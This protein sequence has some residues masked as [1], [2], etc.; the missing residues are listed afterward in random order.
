[1]T[2]SSARRDSSAAAL[3]SWA[4]VGTAC[5]AKADG[6][7]RVLALR[8]GKTPESF[9]NV[10]VSWAMFLMFFLIYKVLEFK[11]LYVTQLFASLRLNVTQPCITRA[12]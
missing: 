7:A 10:I 1:M 11:L 8:A 6:G 12:C 9:V 4:N 5:V 2:S 3:A